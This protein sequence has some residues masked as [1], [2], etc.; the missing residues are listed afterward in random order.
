MTRRIGLVDTTVRDGNQ[1]LWSATGLNTAMMASIAP[2]I[3]RVGYHALDFTSSTHMAV[4]VRWHKEDPWERIRVMRERMPDTP[5]GMIT[6]GRRFMAWEQAPEDVMRLVFRCVVRAGIRRVWAIDPLNNMDAAVRVSEL[7]K[8]EGVEEVVVGLVYAVSPVHT[9][10]YFAERAREVAAS[11]H[12]DVLN[13]K[14]PGGLLTPDRIRALVP[15]LLEAARPGMPVEVHSHCTGALAPLCYLEAAELG[16]EFVCTACA[17]LSNGTSQPSAEQ[18]IA[19]L[20][21]RGFEVDVDE[22]A[23]ARVS[24]HFREVAARQGLPV[25]RPVEHDAGIYKHQLP[26][27]MTTTLQRHLQEAGV[28]G[29]WDELLDEITRVRAELGYPHMVTPI[30]QFIGVQAATNVTTGKRY[31]QVPDELVKYALGQYG[32]PP[33][34]IDPEVQEKLL[35]S[36]R[37]EEFRSATTSFDLDATR[38]R[39]GPNISDEELLLRMMLPE[40]QVEAMLANREPPPRDWAVIQHPLK[41][42]VAELGKRSSVRSAT[43]EADGTRV[44]LARGGA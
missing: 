34:Q 2:V 29:R 30:S 31:G 43:V 10:A 40:Q 19:N 28:E 14:D 9:D 21:A 20:R 12:V 23:L 1:S 42:L 44:H 5:L 22:D 6:P 32:K 11:P 27:G 8:E 36:P 13:L 7:C 4:A 16:A 41:T 24:S 38:E 26:G 15:I 18:T 3:D 17:P 37:A 25:G 35:A 33:G 39:F